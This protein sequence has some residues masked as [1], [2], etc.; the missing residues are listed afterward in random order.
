MMKLQTDDRER[1][2]RRLQLVIRPS[3]YQKLEDLKEHTGLSINEIVNQILS[4]HVPELIEEY[5]ES[6]AE[7]L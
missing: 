2:T 4:E 6:S 7:Q 5:G 3:L 1:K